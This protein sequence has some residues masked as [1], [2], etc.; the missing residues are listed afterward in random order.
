[1]RA[2][3]TSRGEQ[4]CQRLPDCADA[5]RSPSRERALR[6]ARERHRK[7]SQGCVTAVET[8]LAPTMSL[9][10]NDCT[11]VRRPG[12]CA[13]SPVCSSTGTP[14]TIVGLPTR[15]CRQRRCLDCWPVSWVAQ[16]TRP[17]GASRGV[18]AADLTRGLVVCGAHDP[19][20]SNDGLSLPDL[21]SGY[22]VPLWV[23]ASQWS[24]RKQQRGRA[25]AGLA[26]DGMLVSGVKMGKL[27]GPR[28]SFWR[29]PTRAGVWR[30]LPRRQWTRTGKPAGAIASLILVCPSGLAIGLDGV[31]ASAV[32]TSRD[33]LRASEP[34]RS[35]QRHGFTP[36]G[37]P[38]G[39]VF[40]HD[41]DAADSAAMLQIWAWCLG[42]STPCLSET[43]I[44]ARRPKHPMADGCPLGALSAGRVWSPYSIA[45]PWPRVHG[46]PTSWCAWQVGGESVGR[47][48]T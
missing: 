45:S 3:S 17:L 20:V 10:P 23:A 25:R 5:R 26:L 33:E 22:M 46:H 7:P 13:V 30:T 27:A 40:G 42:E 43:G 34:K 36:T 41:W 31:L 16:A 11:S 1:M 37:F 48:G 47:W 8:F 29:Q 9:P 18:Q 6:Q 2:E 15:P 21:V 28:P 39:R 24:R 19:V 32:Y 44:A 4:Q 14:H 12:A 38:T 35:R